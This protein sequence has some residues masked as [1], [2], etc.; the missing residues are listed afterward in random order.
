MPANC[1]DRAAS[2]MFVTT[3]RDRGR[4]SSDEEAEEFRSIIYNYLEEKNIQLDPDAP[5]F[6]GIL[7][8][9]D[10]YDKIKD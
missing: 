3:G 10:K 7:S 1:L 6:S 2:A 5:N 4:G 9:V 8:S